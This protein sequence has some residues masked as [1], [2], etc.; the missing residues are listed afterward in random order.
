[1]ECMVDLYE[2]EKFLE[3]DKFVQFLLNNS[4]DI[5]IPLFILQTVKDKI[6]ELKK[7]ESDGNDI[8]E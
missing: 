2:V 5:A 3:N 7:E 1:M 6:E 4:T 8:D